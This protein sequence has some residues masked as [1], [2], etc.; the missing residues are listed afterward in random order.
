[1]FI[2]LFCTIYRALI[3]IEGDHPK[4]SIKKE[5]QQNENNNSNKPESSSQNNEDYG[6]V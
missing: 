1:V 2:N 4:K 3:N 5:V 6:K